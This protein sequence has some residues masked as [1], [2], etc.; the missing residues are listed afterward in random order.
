MVF[1]G[2]PNIGHTISHSTMTSTLASTIARDFRRHNV[3]YHQSRFD[4]CRN[5]HHYGREKWRTE[6]VPV[7]DYHHR[8]TGGTG[9]GGLDAAG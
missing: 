6:P 5:R 3:R 1:E 2:N 7:V 4:S 9:R 8:I